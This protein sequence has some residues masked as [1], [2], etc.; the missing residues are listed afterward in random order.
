MVKYNAL[1]IGCG[2]IGALYDFD[3][4]LEKVLTH[5]KAY[6]ILRDKIDLTITDLNLEI[7][8]K[9]SI[10]YN[11]KFK[12][13]NEI[14][15]SKY[16]IVSLTTP[17]DTHFNYLKVILENNVPLVICE[18]PIS[19]STIELEELEELRKKSKSKIVVNYIRRFNPYYEKLKYYLESK[20]MISE[21]KYIDIRYCRGFLNNCS[22][23]FDL[24]N[25]LFSINMKLNDFIITEKEYDT[26]QKDPTIS[27]SFTEKDFL[28]NIKGFTSLS[29]FIFEIDFFFSNMKIHIINSGNEIRV[30]EYN[31]GTNEFN[32]IS[33]M[34][35]NNLLKIS[36]FDV[37]NKSIEILENNNLNDN[38]IVSSELNRNMLYAL[39]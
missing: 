35:F 39:N 5:A 13:I 29:Y 33:E 36:M 1:L 38:Y 2:N 9:V 8:K 17:T 3:D 24:I 4:D 12:L 16:Q 15:Y 26:F 28:I 19:L 20:Q 18:K 6:H 11:F 30:Y 31:I 10:K 34:S 14:D 21:I 37:L 7:I 23:A 22:H 27:A 32:F 25:F